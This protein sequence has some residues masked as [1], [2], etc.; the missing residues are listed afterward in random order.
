MATM[1]RLLMLALWVV[2]KCTDAKDQRWTIE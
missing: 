2:E 1:K